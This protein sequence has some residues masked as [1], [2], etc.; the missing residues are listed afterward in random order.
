MLDQ[1][2]P[3]LLTLNEAPNIGRTLSHL[4][5]A[6][7]IV[8]VD[9]GSTDETVNIV[10]RFTNARLFAR[11]FDNHANQW[12]YA[13]SE[14][15]IVTP[16]I[17]RLDADYQLTPELFEE[18]RKLDTK[19]PVNAYRIGFDYAIFARKLRS[20]LYPPNPILLRRGHFTVQDNGHTEAWT[21]DGPV[22][23][24]RARVVHDDWKNTEAWLNAQ[25]RYMRLELDKL[26]SRPCGIRDW[27]RLRPPLMPF[28][29]FIYCLFG[30]GL[31]FNGRAGLFYALQ[32]MTAEATLS[33]ME[34]EAKMRVK[35]GSS[36]NKGQGL[37]NSNI[38]AEKA[39]LPSSN[40]ASHEKRATT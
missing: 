2:T 38:S 40:A 1:I 10:K 33:L 20:S 29:V 4:T 31:I 13:V 36:A 18:L 15:A 12:R 25:G 6:K 19:V 24:L 5:W 23:T 16:W 17:L 28:A 30:K 7:D 9:S 34:L 21:V 35:D 26:T 11:P 14:T 39:R 8:V 37:S 3:V 27:L 22:G 32:R